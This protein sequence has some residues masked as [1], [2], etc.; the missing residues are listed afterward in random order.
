M[1]L[2]KKEIIFISAIVIFLITLFL[3]LQKFPDPI[4][5]Q[6]DKLKSGSL[7]EKLAATEYVKNNKITD[8]IPLLIKN[9]VNKDLSC[10]SVR[11]LNS[12]AGVTVSELDVCEDRIAKYDDLLKDVQNEWEDWYISQKYQGW[13][14]Y[15][16]ESFG[17]EIKYPER[18][19]AWYGACENSDGQYR[20]VDGFVP[21]KIFED[22]NEIYINQAFK[23]QD[24]E[25]DCKK[26]DN[27]I[28]ILSNEYTWKIV[29]Q[30]NINNDQD[31]NKFIRDYY[32]GFGGGCRLGEKKLSKQDGVYDITMYYDGK[33]LGES[34]C[35][36][37]AGTLMKYYPEK[38][39][40]VAWMTGQEPYFWT[41]DK[42][43][44]SFDQA[45]ID[46]FKFIK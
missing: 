26:I 36:I 28:E 27:S 37:N 23:Y 3:L 42:Y 11:S 44:N 38:H 46:S 7:D 29:V 41:D 14:I 45:M 1:K 8:A 6:L 17:I 32:V 9:I 16:S 10:S 40:A 24:G 33:D 15:R 20:A 31:L 5:I 34:S 2:V 4:K 13:Q 12:L 21:T 30:D 35:F 22:N 25:N 18:Y 43:V 19:Y 39:R